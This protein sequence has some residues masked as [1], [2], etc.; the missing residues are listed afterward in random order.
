MIFKFIFC[1]RHYLTISSFVQLQEDDL[2]GFVN[3][4]TLFNHIMRLVWLRQSR[5]GLNFYD[6]SGQGSLYEAVTRPILYN[7]PQLVDILI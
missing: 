7:F 2:P 3:I 4:M 6:V 1:C 5:I